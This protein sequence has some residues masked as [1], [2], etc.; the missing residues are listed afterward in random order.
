MPRIDEP[1]PPRPPRKPRPVSVETRE[2]NTAPPNAYGNPFSPYAVVEG[3]QVGSSS[4]SN[5]G[6][7]NI[8]RQASGIQGDTGNPPRQGG[9]GGGGNRPNRDGGGGGGGGTTSS[10]L[11]PT[12]QRQ[13]N[14]GKTGGTTYSRPGGGGGISRIGKVMNG[15]GVVGSRN[16]ISHFDGSTD[17]STTDNTIEDGGAV[18][19]GGGTGNPLAGVSSAL[20]STSI[21]GSKLEGMSVE[22][23]V[24]GARRTRKTGAKRAE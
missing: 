21:K 22:E 12:R 8:N 18:G 7:Q 10:T 9:D 19:G 16:V 11:S 3:V 20:K 1:R 17:I 4:P 24:R 5:P 15:P 14:T 6:G 2:G 13:T 23:A